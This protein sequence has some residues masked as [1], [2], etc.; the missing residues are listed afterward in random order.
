M[1]GIQ[2]FK[3]RF[4]TVLGRTLD[5]K[6]SE[7]RMLTQDAHTRSVIAHARTLAT[8]GGKRIRPYLA[9]IAYR[10]AG[11]RSVRIIDALVGLELFHVFALVHDDIMDRGA[12]RHGVATAHV[13]F[14]DAQAILVGDLLFN[15]ASEIIAPTKGQPIFAKMVDEVILGQMLDVDA[16]RRDKVTDRFIE[17]K[18]RLKT[19]SYSFIRP[20]QFGVAMAEQEKGKRK[21]GKGNKKK[22]EGMMGFCEKFGLALGMAFQIQDD[23]LDL[24]GTS[25]LLGKSAMNDV[26]E[27]QKTVFTQYASRDPKNRALLNRMK[28]KNLTAKNR[29]R[30]K[31]VFEESG[32]IEKGRR[33]ME[34]YFD[35]AEAV[36]VSMLRPNARLPFLEMLAYIRSRTL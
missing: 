23:L 14:G 5:R 26:K 18:M 28:G 20:M 2:A 19:A 16:T 34:K 31:K 22:E 36:A 15:W 7:M 27:G 4:D 29:K 9:Y 25:K 3:K 1:I 12:S 8:A 10:A 6:M 24:T 30:L 13:K 11:G 32:A 35:E 21:K 33:M 17:D